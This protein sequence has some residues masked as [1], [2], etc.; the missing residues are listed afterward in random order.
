MAVILFV[1]F[2]A[3]YSFLFSSP[4]SSESVESV[5]IVSESESEYEMSDAEY[6]ES[7]Q[8]DESIVQELSGQDIENWT[9]EE[10]ESWASGTEV[11]VSESVVEPSIIDY[12]AMG[13]RELR[14]LV[15]DLGI[16][17]FGRMN[18]A[19]CISHLLS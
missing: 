8:A 17:N 13:V 7:I 6:V 12:S 18:K 14:L 19:T 3:V 2:F 10:I 9:M 11:I 4:V 1:L 15:K 16:K 5:V